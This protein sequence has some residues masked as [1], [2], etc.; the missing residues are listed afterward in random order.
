MT[1]TM[2]PGRFETGPQPERLHML[3]AAGQVLGRAAVIGACVGA[4]INMFAHTTVHSGPLE[5]DVQAQVASPFSPE[6]LSGVT[7]IRIPPVG[8]V[9]LDTHDAPIN[10]MVRP[11]N[12]D[13][14]QLGRISNNPEGGLQLIQ[15]DLEKDLDR[16]KQDLLLKTLLSSFGGLVAGGSLVY[17]FD[18]FRTDRTRR[19]SMKKVMAPVAF[20]GMLGAGVAGSAVYS[21][22]R[23]EDVLQRASYTGALAFAPE[24]IGT[25][26]DSADRFNEQTSQLANTLTYLTRLTDS[27]QNLVVLPDDLRN[28]L[29]VS[30]IHSQP[31]TFD[32]MQRT[33]QQFNIQMIIDAGDLTDRGASFE[34]GLFQQ[35][36]E[37]G[38]P[39][40]FV[41]GNHDS[42]STV[43]ALEE[44]P[45]VVILDGQVQEVANFNLLGSPDPRFTPDRSQPRHDAQGIHRQS[46][47]L[48]K[49]ISR[50]ALSPDIVVAHDPDAAEE[51]VGLVPLFLSGHIHRQVQHTEDGTLQIVSGS[52]GGAGLRAFENGEPTSR[53]AMVLSF[54]EDEL[55]NPNLDQVTYLDFGAID[56]RRS[57]VQSCPVISQVITC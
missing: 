33:I 23:S 37:L 13:T 29:F 8:S 31:G 19:E 52:T 53:T 55:S 12:L 26:Y 35:I 56:E 27:Y 18:N 20:V 15:E 30:D 42:D 43:E 45:N 7:S 21:G 44:I 36:G 3:K 17:L 40:V 11:S 6:E 32:L 39:Y 4:S 14:D 48:V 22:M 51:V 28:V 47:A 57:S 54:A 38:V 34:N 2:Y 46:L 1:A 25:I 50:S 5:F 16:A 49:A 9:E 24:V 41:K 10:I